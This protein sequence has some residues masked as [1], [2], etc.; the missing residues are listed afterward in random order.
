MVNEAY[1]EHKAPHK[2]QGIHDKQLWQSKS[3]RWAEQ[4][5]QPEW[6]SRSW[7][8]NSLNMSSYHT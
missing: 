3:T 8:M 7:N 2:V 4:P 5:R 6:S 1:F